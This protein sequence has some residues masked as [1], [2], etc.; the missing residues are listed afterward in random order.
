MFVLLYL[1]MNVLCNARKCRQYVEWAL[2]YL[3]KRNGGKFYIRTGRPKVSLR[4]WGSPS[5]YCHYVL[6]GK[7]EWWVYQ[8]VKKFDDMF[9]RFDTIHERD[10]QTNGHRTTA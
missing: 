2:Q 6:Y 8:T 9:T 3:Q 1:K 5:E 10:R 4:H 7:L